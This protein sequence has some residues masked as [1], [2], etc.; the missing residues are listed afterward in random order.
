MGGTCC[1]GPSQDDIRVV[2]VSS[3]KHSKNN[4]GT[5]MQGPYSSRSSVDSLNMA[6]GDKERKECA[7]A[8]VDSIFTD[9]NQ[10][11]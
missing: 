11:F 7:Q 9:F 4:T 2:D 5:A 10:E 1:S 3:Q 6:P 8:Y